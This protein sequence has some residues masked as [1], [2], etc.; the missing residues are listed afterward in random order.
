MRNSNSIFSVNIRLWIFLELYE[1]NIFFPQALWFE[2]FC[3]ILYFSHLYLELPKMYG[4]VWNRL[5]CFL[6][7][8]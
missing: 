3:E 5:K 4:N 7:L 2:N 8:M 6:R 1:K